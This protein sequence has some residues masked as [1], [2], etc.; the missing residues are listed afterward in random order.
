[1]SMYLFYKDNFL[2]VNLIKNM[3]YLCEVMLSQFIAY[4]K[5]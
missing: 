3:R 4:D 2:L 1:M 5:S